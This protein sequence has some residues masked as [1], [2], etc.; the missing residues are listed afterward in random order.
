[1]TA[2]LVDDNSF[3]MTIQSKLVEKLGAN[4]FQAYSGSEA[5]D[6]LK[7]NSVDFVLMDMMMPEMDGLESTRQIRQFNPQLLI[8]GLTGNHLESNIQNCKDA[9]M[10]EVLAKPLKIQE[11]QNILQAYRV[12]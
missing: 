9:G 3:M 2:L 4:I 7:K 11:L 12:V 1:M 6:W 10:N 5:I 8:I